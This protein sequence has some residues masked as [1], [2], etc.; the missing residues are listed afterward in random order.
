MSASGIVPSDRTF[1]RW[2][3]SP[4]LNTWASFAARSLS[5]VLILPLLLRI[6]PPDELAVWYVLATLISCQMLA[7][8]GFGPTFVRVI[9]YAMGGA[10]DIREAMAGTQGARG[11]PDFHHLAEIIA[12]MRRV[13]RWLTLLL[14]VGLLVA[15]TL[16]LRRPLNALAEPR[17][18]WISW[19]LVW[20]TTV[21]S[22]RGNFY[23]AWLQGINEIALLRRW[24]ALAA[25][26]AILSSFVVL[27][28]GGRLLAL[29]VSTQFWAV[30]NVLRN[31]WLS[32][33][34]LNRWLAVHPRVSFSPT[35]FAAVWPSAWRSG[36]G[37]LM[38]QG[39]L[40]GTSLI[41]AQSSD[42]A[43]VAGYLLA[44]R[45]QQAIASM[46]NAPFYSKL[47]RFNRW[48]A[49]GRKA[50]MVEAA[51]RA[52]RLTL[53]VFVLPVILLLFWG[54]DLFHMLGSRTPFPSAAVWWVLGA[55]LLV[56]RYAA[57]HL[58]LYSTSNH[59]VWHIANGGTG[60]LTLV[61]AALLFQWLGLLGIPL[62][63]LLG[64]ILFYAP[65]TAALNHRTFP[66]R[67]RTFDL[68]YALLP[69]LVF[70]AAGVGLLVMSR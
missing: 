6:F 70:A 11:G 20:C 44:V 49:E 52:M 54:P 36:I 30:A 31:W 4:T 25:L 15:G 63:L 62:G 47:P 22:F 3:N 58:Q 66:I 34:C 27:Q 35:V 21:V 23:S 13:Y 8:L 10:R 17:D 18:G 45:L 64:N 55:A 68:K 38:S 29:V 28:L 59:I 51:G 65:Y 40:Q 46:A 1:A 67:L 50:E 33:R 56:E 32:R 57:M 37:T 5:L 9:A 12:T 19:L 39:V 26:A 24:E 41:Y 16:A 53:F 14:A 42:G 60:T 61:S 69:A 43:A 7:E 48:W 2:W